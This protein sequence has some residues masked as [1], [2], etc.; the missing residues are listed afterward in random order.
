MTETRLKNFYKPT[1]N[2]PDCL[3][4]MEEFASDFMIKFIRN[5]L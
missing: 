4:E 3:N 5:A 1:D 2:H